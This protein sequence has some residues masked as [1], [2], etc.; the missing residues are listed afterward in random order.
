MELTRSQSPRLCIH[1][2][3]VSTGLLLCSKKK[4]RRGSFIESNKCWET[5]WKLENENKLPIFFTFRFDGFVGLCLFLAALFVLFRL[6]KFVYNLVQYYEIRAFYLYALKISAVSSLFRIKFLGVLILWWQFWRND[7][8]FHFVVQEELNNMTWHEVQ[9]RL[10]D[11]QK[12][13][14]MCVH[15]SELTQLGKCSSFSHQNLAW[16]CEQSK[17]TALNFALFFPDIYHRI[18][19]FKNYMVA[20]VN[21]SVLPL[22]MRVPFVGE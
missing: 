8:H 3:S 21:K 5:L 14:Q 2:T 12:E 9:R 4:K 16:W 6:L 19:R 11:V 20:M 17:G 13:Q 10:L 7:N 15:K 18:L 22:Q 1:W